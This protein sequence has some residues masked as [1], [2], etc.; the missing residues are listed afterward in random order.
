MFF[1]FFCRF[2]RFQTLPN[3][4]LAKVCGTISRFRGGKVKAQ[5]FFGVGDGKVWNTLPETN[6]LPMKSSCFLVNTIQNGE[7]SSQLC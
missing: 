6:S 5:P 1:R 7:F 2:R 3:L 4:D